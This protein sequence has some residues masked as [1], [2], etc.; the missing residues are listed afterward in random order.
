MIKMKNLLAENMLR[1][2]S[3]NLSESVKQNLQRLIEQAS[4]GTAADPA[5]D[6][7]FIK[8]VTTYWNT[9]LNDPAYK[10]KS[11]GYRMTPYIGKNY[12]AAMRIR[13]NLDNG[14]NFEYEAMTIYPSYYNALLLPAV[15]SS[16]G[17]VSLTNTRGTIDLFR[18]AE[19]AQLKSKQGVQ[20]MAGSI[21]GILDIN[22]GFTYMAPF[23]SGDKLTEYLAKIK[24]QFTQAAADTVKDPNWK[25]IYDS[26]KN[27]TAKNIL[28]QLGYKAS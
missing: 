5:K 3:K 15:A 4:S 24:P 22:L 27:T 2:G 19:L 6:P 8:A 12:I 11:E 25:A 23:L 28:D 20:D 10:D 18:T 9:L 21:G 17:D 7:G 26:V 1:F 14:R 13:P 16:R